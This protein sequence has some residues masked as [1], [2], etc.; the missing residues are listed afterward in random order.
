MKGVHVLLASAAVV[1]AV[2]AFEFRPNCYGWPDTNRAWTST[3][4]NSLPRLLN[5]EAP[6]FEL[7]TLDQTA[8]VTLEN[9][10]ATAP[11]VLQ[12]ADYS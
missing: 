6:N 12:F 2:S 10:L 5:A 1:A 4:G 11:V 9:L 3:A 7:R 8:T